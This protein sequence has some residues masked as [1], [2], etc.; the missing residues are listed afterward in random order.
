MHILRLNK[1]LLT[2]LNL[3]KEAVLQDIEHWVKGKEEM[4]AQGHELKG[5]GRGGEPAN[6]T[7]KLGSEEGRHQRVLVLGSL[8]TL[9]DLG[10][11]LHK[12]TPA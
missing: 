3:R 11:K 5:S 6:G 2:R 8:S 12:I 4:P 1:Y 9:E 10:Q 7:R